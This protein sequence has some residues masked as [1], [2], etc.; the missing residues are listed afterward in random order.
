MLDN[1]NLRSSPFLFLHYLRSFQYVYSRSSFM[2]ERVKVAT[3]FSSLY[4]RLKPEDNIWVPQGSI[5]DS[6]HTSSTYFRH[7]QSSPW[8]NVVFDFLRMSPRISWTN[9]TKQ[10]QTN[11]MMHNMSPLF[12]H[13][14]SSWII[15][16]KNRNTPEQ[17]AVNVGYVR[18]VV[19][20]FCSRNP[21]GNKSSRR[22][23]M[24]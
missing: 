4:F 19:F 18:R 21:L 8:K 11:L 5:L 7:I 23:T 3:C 24:I 22:K 12:W 16:D 17:T 2:W 10:M 9:I 15:H 20:C 14:C 6:P 13:L 1:F